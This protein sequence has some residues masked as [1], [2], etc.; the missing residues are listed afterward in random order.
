MK[1]LRKAAMNTDPACLVVIAK[2]SLQ[3]GASKIVSLPS[4]KRFC[5]SCHFG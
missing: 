4:G 3:S 5:I 1:P 2:L